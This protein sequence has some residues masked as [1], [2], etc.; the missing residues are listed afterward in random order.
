MSG[1]SVSETSPEA[2]IETMI[3]TANSRKM[4]PMR[5]GMRTSGMKT[6]ASESV[7]ERIV[8]LISLALAS[9]ASRAPWPASMRRTVFSRKTIA[10]S[11]RKPIAS[12]RAMS[13]RL[14]RL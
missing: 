13:E 9:V 5:P 4:R 3:V 7:M 10:S 11:T 12:V 2:Q 14:S 8:K 1:V 6:A